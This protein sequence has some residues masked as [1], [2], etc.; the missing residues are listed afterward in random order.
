[1]FNVYLSGNGHIIIDVN[2]Y[3]APAGSG[4]WFQPLPNP[5]RVIDTRASAAYYSNT[6]PVGGQT[7]FNRQFRG[8]SYQG[9]TIPDHAR[10]VSTTIAMLPTGGSGFVTVWPGPNQ[11][12]TNIIYKIYINFVIYFIITSL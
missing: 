2:G 3:F 7:I 8:I 11:V 5:I 10:A 6:G 12:C 9:I 4:L 1:M